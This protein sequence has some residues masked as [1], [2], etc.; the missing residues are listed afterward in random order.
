MKLFNPSQFFDYIPNTEHAMQ[1]SD[2]AN[3]IL[4][5]WLDDA[6]DVTGNGKV[7]LDEG[8]DTN[9]SPQYRAKLVCVE[10]IEKCNHANLKPVCHICGK[11]LHIAEYVEL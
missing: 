10:K 7:W 2:L 11:Q 8:M 9:A 6:K 4:N 3:I 1:A 5:N